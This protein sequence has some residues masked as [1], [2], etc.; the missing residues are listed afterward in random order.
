MEKKKTKSPKKI[1][2]L[3]LFCHICGCELPLMHPHIM[4]ERND[5]KG[6]LI[7]EECYQKL[8]GNKKKI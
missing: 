8:C 6:N 7:C 1:T 5:D 3:E 4:L 2:V